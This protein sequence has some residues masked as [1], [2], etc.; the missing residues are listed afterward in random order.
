MFRSVNG[1]V[2]RINFRSGVSADTCRAL[3]DIIVLTVLLFLFSAA[4]PLTLENVLKVVEGVKDWK[5]LCFGFGIFDNASLNGIRD[6]VEMFL[7]GKSICPR[8]PTWRSV[9]FALDKAGEIPLA[10]CIRSYGEPVQGE[11]CVHFDYYTHT[12]GQEIFMFRATSYLNNGCAKFYVGV[13]LYLGSVVQARKSAVTLI[14][15]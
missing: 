13:H 14:Y 4:P 3:F 2:T 10:N 9:I 11:G 12:N 15:L 1:R 8:Q 5:L 7:L 6:V